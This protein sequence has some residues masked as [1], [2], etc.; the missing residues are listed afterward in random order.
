MNEKSIS[1]VQQNI[2]QLSAQLR[3]VKNPDEYY[4]IR[5]QLEQAESDLEV[6][7]VQRDLRNVTVVKER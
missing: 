3:V 1:E 5:A 7:E 4:A 2:N 6:L